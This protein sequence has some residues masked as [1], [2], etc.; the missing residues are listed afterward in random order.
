MKLKSYLITDPQYYTNNPTQ[1]KNSLIKV[2]Q[3]FKLNFVCFR[4]KESENYR[5]LAKIFIEISKSFKIEKILIN[6]YIDLAKE[7][8]FD[9]VH[10]TSTQFDKIEYAKSLNLYTICSTH[11]INEIKECELKGVNA[12]SFSPIFIT[13]NKGKPKGIEELKEVLKNSNIKIFGLGGIISQK[14]IK[15]LSKTSIY[16]F[17]SIRYFV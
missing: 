1:F 14:H 17:A 12:I 6:S 15:E 3:N 2:Y 7:L 4:D 11:N 8:N 13:P 5:E 9:G 16:G 10:L